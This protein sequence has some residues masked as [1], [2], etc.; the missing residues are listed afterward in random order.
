M[1]YNIFYYRYIVLNHIISYHIILLLPKKITD[2]ENRH[3]E[4]VLP[5][6]NVDVF[7]HSFVNLSVFTL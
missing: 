3:C 2:C 5:Q 1:H 7:K 4:Y 6:C